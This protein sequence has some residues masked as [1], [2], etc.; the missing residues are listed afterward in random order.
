MHLLRTVGEL[1][2][3]QQKLGFMMSRLRKASPHLSP[4]SIFSK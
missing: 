1:A 3:R 2:E 4:R